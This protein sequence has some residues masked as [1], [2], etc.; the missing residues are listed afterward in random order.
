[1]STYTIDETDTMRALV[2]LAPSGDRYIVE[3]ASLWD[4]DDNCVGARIIAVAGPIY[5]GD[6]PAD[7]PAAFDAIDNW[8]GLTSEDA[9][10]MQSEAD[11]GR[12][13]YPLGAR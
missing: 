11:A 7:Q 2:R 12:V 4:A 5:H 6:L 1:M 8:E 3:Q 10:W 13:T 9:E